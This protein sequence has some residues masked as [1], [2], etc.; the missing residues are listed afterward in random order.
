MTAMTR[1]QAM[2]TVGASMA[3]SLVGFASRAATTTELTAVEWGGGVVD[4]LKQIA[5]KQDKVTFNWVLHQGGSGAILPKIKATWPNAE[6]DYVAG[7]EGSFN[8]M[9]KE[10]WLV[11]VSVDTIPNLADIPEKIIVKNAKGDWMAVPRA[12]GGIYFAYR[13]D[14]SPVKIKSI[15]DLFDPSLKG[16]ICWPGPTQSMMLQLVAL[17]LHDGG[18]ENNLEPGWELMKKLA[19]SGN[20]GRI[21]VTDTDFTTSLTSGETVAG[22]YS[23]P[24]LTEVAKQFPVVRLTKQEGMP[25]FLYQ[26]GFAVFKNR[27]NLQATLDFINFAISAEMSELYAQVAGEAPLN[28]KAKTPDALKHLAFTPEEFDKYVYVPNFDVVLTQQDAWA[29]RWE[30]EI[31]PL[32]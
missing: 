20:I 7:W 18:N 3:M 9:L 19:K 11:P 13:D 22:F 6:Y 29:K 26:S 12:V 24:Q 30:D 1:R 25:V 5:A 27:P 8:G 21:A 10:D 14:I 4:A 17:A 23:E 31:A 28:K 15:D 32:L 2:Q 16:K